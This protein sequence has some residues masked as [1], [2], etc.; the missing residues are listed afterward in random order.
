VNPARSKGGIF[1]E[2]TD[3]I[4]DDQPDAETRG[5][6]VTTAP[7]PRE[8][9]SPLS[10]KSTDTSPMVGSMTSPAPSTG[11][12]VTTEPYPLVGTPAPA[13]TASD[14]VAKTPPSGSRAVVEIRQDA[15][16]DAILNKLSY[17]RPLEPVTTSET[18]GE[19]SA[20]HAAGPIALAPGVKTPPLQAP[21]MVTDSIVNGRLP[22]AA[23]AEREAQTVIV[24]NREEPPASHDDSEARAPAIEPKSR[25]TAILA[26]LGGVIVVIL[27]FA[28]AEAGFFHPQKSEVGTTSGAAVQASSPALPAASGGPALTATATVPET[29]PAS[30]SA[31]APVSPSAATSDDAKPAEPSGRPARATP[32]PRPTPPTNGTSRKIPAAPDPNSD[33]DFQVGN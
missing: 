20:A 31:K 23:R 28:L 3:S 18:S 9:A 29:P 15:T 30:P 17:P 25:T 6:A 11:A 19:L 13:A 24:R 22:A 26:A 33:H 32:R 14:V 7:L 12:R 10:K 21:V 27:V 1:A 4:P 2:W 5:P 16:I 8:S